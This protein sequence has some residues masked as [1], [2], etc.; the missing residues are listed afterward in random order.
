MMD[1]MF[2]YK[3]IKMPQ[4]KVLCVNVCSK[5][6]LS[7]SAGTCE[8]AWLTQ[9]LTLTL[10]LDTEWHD[11]SENDKNTIKN[12]SQRNYCSSYNAL[13]PNCDN[14]LPFKL[15]WF[16]FD[17]Q[18]LKVFARLPSFFLHFPTLHIPYC[19]DG[20]IFL[21]FG[22]LLECLSAGFVPGWHWKPECLQTEGR[23]C[24]RRSVA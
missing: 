16:V 8:M 19:L 3:V 1:C 17:L 15:I 18:F 6:V 10:T 22:L 11:Y 24:R 14:S 7:R 4:L 5:H 23:Y 9:N 2:L 21:F 12:W 20:F 13:N